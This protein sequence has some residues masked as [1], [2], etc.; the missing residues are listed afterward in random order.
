MNLLQFVLWVY[1]RKNA[2]RDSMHSSEWVT[3]RAG[4]VSL[5]YRIIVCNHSE[6]IMIWLQWASPNPPLQVLFLICPT[7]SLALGT[8]VAFATVLTLPFVVLIALSIVSI[9]VRSV[10]A[11]PRDH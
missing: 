2:S 9:S 3:Q 1:D 4:S 6:C 10:S 8:N 7:S 5:V 11:W